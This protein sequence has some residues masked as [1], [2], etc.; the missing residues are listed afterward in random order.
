MNLINKTFEP[1][2]D[3]ELYLIKRKYTQNFDNMSVKQAVSLLKLIITMENKSIVKSFDSDLHDL[4][5]RRLHMI[6]DWTN[7]PER[8]L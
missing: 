4:L 8:L 7:Y 5:L 2:N 1:L 6:I 3:N